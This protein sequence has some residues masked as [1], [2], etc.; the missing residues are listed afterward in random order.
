MHVK[1]F[2]IEIMLYIADSCVKLICLNQVKYFKIPLVKFKCK[3][4]LIFIIIIF[5]FFSFR[6]RYIRFGVE[7][8]LNTFQ[9]YSWAQVTVLVWIFW[10][11]ACSPY[12]RIIFLLKMN[13]WMIQ[14]KKYY[15]GKSCLSL[16][17]EFWEI[18]V[19]IWHT[20]KLK[21]TITIRSIYIK[22]VKCCMHLNSVWHWALG[23]G[24]IRFLL[25]YQHVIVKRI[26]LDCLQSFF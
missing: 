14:L 12:F 9:F 26:K 24:C 7:N 5:H 4:L 17:I 16:F 3:R 18:L 25:V 2:I 13:E 11:F 21:S 19:K 15:S 22:T 20:I 10:C 1:H 23:S 8:E 6:F